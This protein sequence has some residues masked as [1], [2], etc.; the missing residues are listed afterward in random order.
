MR[1]HALLGALACAL[2]PAAAA[3]SPVVF[4]PFASGLSQP[5]D[6]QAVPNDPA[7]LYVVEKG[8]TVRLIASG[9]LRAAPVLDLSARIADQ[10]ELGLLGLAFDPAWPDSAFVYVHYTRDHPAVPPLAQYQTVIARVAVDPATHVAVAGGETALLLAEQENTNHAGG[11][12]AFGPGGLLHVALGDG[13]RLTEG[14]NAA[15]LPGSILRLDVRGRGTPLDCGAGSATVPA[16]NPLA[17]G[18]GGA[19]DEIYAYGFR[20]PWRLSFDAASGRLWV[21]DVGQNNWEEVDTV[22]AGGNYGWSALEGTHCYDPPT[23]CDVPG[24][25]PPVW[26]YDRTAGGSVTGGYVY[27]GARV[28][29][30][31][32]AYVFADFISGAVWAL[33]LGAPA[34]VTALGTLGSASV[35]S[36]GVDTAGSSTS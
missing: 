33:R 34:T 10:G 16:S 27:H 29:A 13:T 4:T 32:G 5:V 35:T 14:Q 12:V 7:R 23:A 24:A 22:A 21:G 18:P 3:Q 20:N 36:F 2:L 19:C 25:R 31:A 15:S 1:R 26:E 8:G 11:S 6:F 30:L 9:V 17:D 28:P